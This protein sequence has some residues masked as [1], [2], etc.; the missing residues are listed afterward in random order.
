MPEAPEEFVQPSLPQPVPAVSPAHPISPAEKVKQFPASP[1]VYIMK[2][3][4]ARV[5]YVGKAK[6]LRNRAGHYFSRAAEVDSRT[7]D[8]VK[9]IRDID[10]I[11]AETEVDALLLEARLIKDVQ[12]P[13]NV[14]LKDDKTFPYLQI[15]IR[16]DFPRVEFTR[17]PRRKGV[18]LYGPFT[19][20]ASLRAAIQVLQRIFQFRT[21]SLDIKHDDVRWRWFRPCI[22]HNIHQC[23][24]PCNLRV[25]REDYRKQIRALRMVLEGKKDKLL[26]EM[27]QDMA[28]ASAALQFEKAAR[29]RDEVKA[30]RTLSLR[31]DVDKN[32]QPEVFHI[33]PK[34]GL[35]GLRKVLGLSKTPRIIE[36][37]DIAHLSGDEMVASLVCFIDG[38]PFKPGYRRYKIRTVQGVDDFASIREVVS[39]RFRKPAGHGAGK[40]ERVDP[41]ILLIDG[42]KG[43]LH[44][45][46]EV[47]QMMGREPP[48]LISLAKREEEIFRTGEADPLRLSRHAAGLR[49]LQYVRDEAHRFAQHYHHLLR[50]K[51]LDD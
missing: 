35:I 14:T 49:L 47:F 32:V 12:P 34:K 5:L 21:C 4:Q 40:E 16:E 26:A 46:L 36:G 39:R 17:T 7:A 3:E 30:L 48:C 31:G 9:Q 22:L 50:K 38:L 51:K 8:L 24:A 6:N 19:R 25:S 44:A 45:A 41:D 18:K 20:A 11:Q 37:V 10:F 1:G 33:E 43:Q 27:E 2:D 13:F 15:R 42:G 28:D 23:T 29:L